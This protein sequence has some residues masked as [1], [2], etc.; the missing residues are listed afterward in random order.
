MAKET[1]IKSASQNKNTTKASKKKFQNKSTTKLSNK[2]PTALK[3]QKSQPQQ[4]NFRLRIP[5][6]LIILLIIISTIFV[7]FRIIEPAI[8][9]H[10]AKEYLRNKYN[11]EFSVRETTG[12]RWI[13][14]KPTY[15]WLAKAQGDTENIEF[16]VICGKDKG[17]C[18][19]RYLDLNLSFYEK[20]KLINYIGGDLVKNISIYVYTL[21]NGS[22]GEAFLTSNLQYYSNKYRIEYVV[23]IDDE[24]SQNN[25][26][27]KIELI[28]KIYDYLKM[29]NIEDVTLTYRTV[30]G[31][32]KYVCNSSSNNST[33]NEE[34]FEKAY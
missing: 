4:P 29:N 5:K 13:G 6:W 22:D 2:K 32:D 27:M 7:Y 14:Q 11:K 25:F 23:K 1:R 28:N 8:H 21:I 33:I 3:N 24:A 18:V 15:Y 10:L 12:P 17:D 9:A 31:D 19:D 34:C 20:K 16:S 30:I 26:N